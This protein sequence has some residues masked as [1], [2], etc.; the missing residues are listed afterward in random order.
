MH[1][2]K[3]KKIAILGVFAAL[4]TVLRCLVL[5]FLSILCFYGIGGISVR[6]YCSSLW[7]QRGNPFL[8]CLCST[9][10]FVNPNKM[11]VILYLALA[12]YILLSEGI[13]Y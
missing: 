1:V 5:L 9:G 3:T 7:N 12:A 13:F 6:N 11:H 2:N 8:F 4:S 10:L